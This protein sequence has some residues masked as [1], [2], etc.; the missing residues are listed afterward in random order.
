MPNDLL[1]SFL[2]QNITALGDIATLYVLFS[3]GS[4]KERR[5]PGQHVVP[6]EN[7]YVMFKHKILQL[8]YS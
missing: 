4:K 2:H 3:S 1:V 8:L 7:D 5:F 6:V